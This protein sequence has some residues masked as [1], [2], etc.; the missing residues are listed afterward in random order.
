MMPTVEAAHESAA[1]DDASHLRFVHKLIEE[2]S[3]AQRVAS[4]P[5]PEVQALHNEARSLY[6]RAVEAHRFDD[7]EVVE[8]AL[9]HATETMFKAVRAAEQGQGRENNERRD[10]E[11]LQRSV[12]ALM[13]A[14][15][16]V[17]DEKGAGTAHHDL[18]QT[19]A[20]AVDKAHELA[21]RG[22][23][24]EAREIL[25]EAYVTIKLAVRELRQGE[26]LVRSLHFETKQEEYE[27][28]LDRN[29]THHMLVQL[30]I[31]E[32][33]S[34]ESVKA[35]VKRFVDKAVDL[36]KEAEQQAARD[37]YEAAVETLEESTKQLV[38]A[39]RGAGMFIPM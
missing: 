28:E 26:T 21:E 24:H 25:A 22:R 16:R 34:S 1:T 38:R 6:R 12:D 9:F 31:E 32:K 4:S 17:S 20:P 2:S 13:E 35:M 39:I 36:R 11:K 37:D 10:L 8:E 30:L 23:L 3:A 27:Y 19:I 29:D 14:H 7:H 15:A 18:E 5:D 33:K